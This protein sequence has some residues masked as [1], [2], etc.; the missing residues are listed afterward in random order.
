MKKAMSAD[1]RRASGVFT[2]FVLISIAAILISL[3]TGTLPIPPLKVIQTFFGYGDFTS[4]TVL[5][6]YR[7][8]RILITMLAGIEIGRAHV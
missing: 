7:L 1:A 6:D 3:N 5:F 2:L 8:P 4:T